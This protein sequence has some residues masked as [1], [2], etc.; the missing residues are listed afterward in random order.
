MNATEARNRIHSDNACP[1]CGITV[2]MRRS[3][4]EGTAIVKCPKCSYFDPITVPEIEVGDGMTLTIASDSE[5]YTVVKVSPNGKT[6]TLQRDRAVRTNREADTFE[7][8]GFVGHTESPAGQEWSY[9]RD[10][11][12]AIIKATWR[13]LRGG[14]KLAGSAT[15]SP[16]MNVSP[17]RHE[18]YD[19]NY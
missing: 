16:G 7:P 10:P 14:Y 18:H 15:R 4:F 12:G 5:A 2:R 6:L 11:D 1:W 3:T 13:D 19:Y 8:G 17:G 9:E